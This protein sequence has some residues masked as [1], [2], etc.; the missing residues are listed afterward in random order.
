M[1]G[2]IREDGVIFISVDDNE[3]D[4]LK[5]TCDEIFGEENFVSQLV[6]KKSYG[7][8]AKVKHVVG[9]HEYINV[10]ARNKESLGFL[11]LPHDPKILKYYKSPLR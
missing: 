2:V 11:E 1:T 5:K 4:N 3:A 10:Y 7:G 9:L 8:G 6:W